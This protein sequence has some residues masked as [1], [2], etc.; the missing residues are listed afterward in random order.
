MEFKN[1]TYDRMEI[2]NGILK[3]YH[4]CEAE[5]TIP[6]K[7]V[8]IGNNAFSGCKSLVNVIIPDNVIGIGYYAFKDCTGLTKITIPDNLADI[9]EGAFYN[10]NSLI[11]ITIP[12]GTV[13]GSYAFVRCDSLQFERY[14]NAYY[15][16]NHLIKASSGDIATINIRK[17]TKTITDNAF[18]CCTNLKNITIPDGVK[19]IG[20]FAFGYCVSLKKLA[21][22][23]SVAEIKAGAFEGCPNLEEIYYEK[24]KSQW[25]E[26]AVAV[27][28]EH[29]GSKTVIHCNDG[30]LEFKFY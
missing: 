7:V 2:E 26:L 22:P 4:G 8:R 20:G 24:E 1:N 5:V 29:M 16:N 23:C 21:I 18:S 13:I 15:L 9:C 19:N 14:D 3:K 27:G 6:D 25:K 30:N 10:C 11:N 12:D 28:K 17:G